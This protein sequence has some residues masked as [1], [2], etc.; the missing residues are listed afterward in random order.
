MKI[1]LWNGKMY[2]LIFLVN[3]WIFQAKKS[4]LGNQ[5]QS[6]KRYRYLFN[7]RPLMKEEKNS[8]KVTEPV[9]KKLFCRAK[10]LKIVRFFFLFSKR[11]ISSGLPNSYIL[12]GQR[13]EIFDLYF[14][15]WIEPIWAP[16]KQAKMVFL[17]NL[18]PWRYLSLKLEKFDSEQANTA[19]IWTFL[20][21]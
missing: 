17:K 21:C 11:P 1:H 8:V 14:F 2:N 19:R 7:E 16:D 9:K 20:T 3:R 10:I 6:N 13:H 15:S 4:N 5:Y 18:F 12:K